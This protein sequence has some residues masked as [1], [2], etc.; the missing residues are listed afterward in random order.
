MDGNHGMVLPLRFVHTT[1]AIVL[2]CRTAHS[3]D[4]TTLCGVDEVKFILT[5]NAVMLQ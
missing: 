2:R 4:V 1:P 5:L 3:C